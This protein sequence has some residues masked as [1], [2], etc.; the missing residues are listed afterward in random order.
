MKRLAMIV[1]ATVLTSL[2]AASAEG[3]CYTVKN[4]NFSSSVNDGARTLL[5]CWVQSMPEYTWSC[6]QYS[7][8]NTKYPQWTYSAPGS[9]CGDGWCEEKVWNASGGQVLFSRFPM[10]NQATVLDSTDWQ[11][12][13]WRCSLVVV[14]GTLQ[15]KMCKM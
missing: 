10:S 8:K 5:Q 1:F 3:P 2:S 4:Y 11:G 12:Q 9:R 7:C 15:T 13:A 14:N 6:S